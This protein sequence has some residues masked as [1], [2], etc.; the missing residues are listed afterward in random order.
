MNLTEGFNKEFISNS[1]LE[2]SREEVDRKL[3]SAE[4]WNF[5][6]TKFEIY[7]AFVSFEENEDIFKVRPVVV[8]TDKGDTVDCYKVTSKRKDGESYYQKYPIEEWELAGLTKPC[9]IILTSKVEISKDFFYKKL[10]KLKSTDI[11]NLKEFG[12]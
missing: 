11:D 12:L 5:N 4:R 9:Y 8:I 2:F 6:Y 7:K 3:L 10:G 1:D